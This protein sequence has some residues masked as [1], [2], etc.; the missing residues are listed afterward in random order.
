MDVHATALRA[1]PRSRARANEIV[2]R[3]ARL[4]AVIVAVQIP[5]NLIDFGSFGYRYSLVNPNDEQSLFAWIG[6]IAIMSGAVIAATAYRRT[7]SRP[8]LVAA[9]FLAL[10]AIE[11]RVRVDEPAVHRAAI[12]IP[13]LGGL[14]ASL[15]WASSPWP[16]TARRGVLGGLAFLAFSLALH[17]IAPHILLHY[18]YGP[19]TWPY[20]TKVSLKETS[21]MAGWILIA[22]GLLA[23]LRGYEPSLSV[24]AARDAK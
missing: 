6:A 24:V 4:A 2:P 22:G 3:A 18:G 5:A 13:L 12:Y 14:A 9:A 11:N 19:G 1:L 23:A 8:Y 15:V 16:A 17:K 21:E 7:K 10:V 20:E